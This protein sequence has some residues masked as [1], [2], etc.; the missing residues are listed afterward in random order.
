LLWCVAGLGWL[1][2]NTHRSKANHESQI[3]VEEQVLCNL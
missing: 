3:Q 1:V 2:W